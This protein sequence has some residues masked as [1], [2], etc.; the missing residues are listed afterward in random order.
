MGLQL[1]WIEWVNKEREHNTKGWR[2]EKR[3]LAGLLEGCGHG[4]S[5]FWLTD[6]AVRGEGGASAQHCSM[7]LSSTFLGEKGK[8][9]LFAAETRNLQMD[10]LADRAIT[11][12][13]NE[14]NVQWQSVSELFWPV[15]YS[16]SFTLLL[17]SNGVVISFSDWRFMAW[18]VPVWMSGD[19]YSR[20]YSLLTYHA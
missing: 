18:C 6:L 11:L 14:E 19:K 3:S 12:Q 20:W 7:S 16:N 8:F 4:D 1:Q 5:K 9:G 10:T 13:M 17:F 2:R 15:F